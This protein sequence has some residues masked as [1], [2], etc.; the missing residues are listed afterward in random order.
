MSMKPCPEQVWEGSGASVEG[1]ALNE[2]V[3]SRWPSV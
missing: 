3:E 2:S 1:I